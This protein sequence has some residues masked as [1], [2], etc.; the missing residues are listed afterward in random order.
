MLTVGGVF[1]EL[2]IRV[3]TLG[4][5]LHDLAKMVITIVDVFRELAI[6]MPNGACLHR[7]SQ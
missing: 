3:F 1:R 2:P 4:G 7:G 6:K 5:V